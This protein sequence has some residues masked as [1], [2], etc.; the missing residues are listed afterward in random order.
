MRVVYINLDKYTKLIS[1]FNSSYSILVP[2]ALT[3]PLTIFMLSLISWQRK[4]NNH[5]DTKKISKSV[6]KGERKQKNPKQS[7]KQKV[8]FNLFIY[9]V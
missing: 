4:D 6:Q 5:I 1:I 8:T 2:S 3:V 9:R 7:N